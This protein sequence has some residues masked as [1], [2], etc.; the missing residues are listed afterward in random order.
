MNYIF[1][2]LVSFTLEFFIYIFYLLSLLK[3][4][5][6]FFKTKKCKLRKNNKNIEVLI[7]KSGTMGDHLICIDCLDKISKIDNSIKKT[8]VC[9][10]SSIFP[11]LKKFSSLN[12]VELIPYKLLIDYFFKNIF[13]EKIKLIIDTEPYFRLGLLFGLIMPKSIISSN[14]RIPYDNHFEKFYPYIHFNHYDENLQEGFYIIKLINNSIDIFLKKF[15]K[16]SRLRKIKAI[17]FKN[18]FLVLDNP[19]IDLKKVKFHDS[20]ISRTNLENRKLVYLY[21]GC[22]G[23]AM[24]RLPPVNWLK[25]FVKLLID[26]YYIFYVGGP[27]EVRLE[28]LLGEE[29]FS[30]YSFINNFSLTDWSMI[31][32]HSKYRIPLISFDGGFS[33]LFGINSPMIFQVFCSSN[34]YKW[35]NKS[36]QSFVYSCLDGGSPNYKPFKFRVPQECLISQNAWLS[37]KE[38]DLFQKFDSWFENIKQN[39]L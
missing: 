36:D 2:L 35:R 27:S 7:F 22:S 3:S 4:F 16:N 26:R 24:H 32:N 5:I 11:D 39:N 12:N 21:Y 23:K 13:S 8:I 10:N 9:K 38:I 31:L 17:E 33:H 14:Y 28:N 25:N 37:S 6:F 20:F 30:S 29:K 19:N 15:E 1:K 18:N 34:N